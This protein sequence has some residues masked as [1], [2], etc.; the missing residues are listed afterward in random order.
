MDNQK[1]MIS[2]NPTKT[3]AN[4]VNLV[5]ALNMSG[6]SMA[7]KSPN[8]GHHM[9]YDSSEAEELFKLNRI[10]ATTQQEKNENE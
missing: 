6:L 3:G 2:N 10:L 8:K 7:L 5:P 9:S 4:G 1:I